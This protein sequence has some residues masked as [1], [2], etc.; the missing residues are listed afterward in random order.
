MSF[1]PSQPLG[2]D[3]RAAVGA[4]I[5][6]FL[7]AQRPVLADIGT[8]L[9]EAWLQAEHFTSG[10][11]RFRPAFCYWGHV[12]AGGQPSD[13][14]P[15]LDVAGS[16]DLLHVSALVH[17]DV[18]DGSDLRRGGPSSHRLF[19]AWHG[20]RGLRGAAEPFGRAGAILLGDL[21]LVW[22]I[23]MVEAAAV[24][25]ARRARAHSLLARVRTEVTCGQYL[26]MLAQITPPGA[27]DIDR[28][29]RVVE[30]KTARY[31]VMRP[32]Q[33]GAALG[34]APD[35]LIDALEGF[36]S[37]VGRAFQYRDDLL[38]VFGD[39]SVT[40]KPSGDDLREGKRTV[41][42]ARALAGSTPAAAARL[43][44]LLGDPA[45]SA[46]QVDD[47]R[48]IIA[49]SG[50]VA[51]MEGEIDA[52]AAVATSRLDGLDITTEG[53]TALARLA[54]LATRRDA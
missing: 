19:E 9:D 39:A 40:G 42:V 14:G 35:V 25:P 18:M 12:A 15:V 54:A 4:A 29:V 49:D 22:S 46:D 13:P 52:L 38:G 1:D 53:R 51:V 27:G 21:L 34:G 5:T 48:T 41:L 30:Y 8:D 44:G 3:F 36:A 33:I 16:L 2:E 6:A 17:D 20:V 45:L 24:D 43:D 47:A 37:P 50:A 23:Q 7:A 11:K 26:D 32:L 10:G 28:A 31:T